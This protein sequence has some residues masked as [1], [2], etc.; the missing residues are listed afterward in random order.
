M[1]ETAGIARSG[2]VVRSGVP[3]PRSL[4]MRDPNVLTL[5]D[6]AGIPVPA[7]FQVLARW[8]AGRDADA[9]IQWLLVTF[10]AS[11]AA[12]GSAT[13]RLVTDGSAGPNPVPAVAVN[14]TQTGNQIT[15][16]TGAATFR[17]GVN[18]GALFDEIRL[19]NG[20]RLVSGSALTARVN[21]TD[22]AHPTTRR[23]A[24]EHVGPLTAI[25]VVEGAYDLPP[26][27]GG[28]LGSRRRYVFTAG[29]PTAIV[30]QRLRARRTDPPAFEVKVAG[31]TMSGSQAD[32]GVLAVS[33][34]SGALALALNHMHRYEPQALRLLAD[35]RLAVDMADDQVWLGARQGL[36]A[37]LAVSA[38]ADNP[39]RA[40]LNRL[41][42]APLNRPLRAW[43]EPA[44]FAASE[45]VD[46]I[47]AGP[48]PTD[49]ADYDTL[50]SSVLITTLQKVD[51][52]GLPGLMTFGVYPRYWGI[53][54]YGDGEAA[55]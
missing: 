10:P 31:T 19:A 24:L 32:G 41:V 45:A 39:S 34:A 36:F 9:P 14:V 37:T 21:S 4:D 5:V 33:G 3:L 6:A 11:V 1:R 23:V 54:F 44:W 42:W 35:G 15:V 2:E 27:G 29:S 49:L 12:N 40:D 52:K 25:V 8:G 20:T 26:V 13:Y 43:P 55:G 47:P 48:L 17:L 22:V 53:P 50:V 51:E 30:R 38:L 28:G 16:D 46:E 18:P 7:E